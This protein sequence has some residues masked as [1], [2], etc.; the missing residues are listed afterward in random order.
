[1]DRI[2]ECLQWLY[3]SGSL[4]KETGKILNNLGW[5]WLDWM[6]RD[7]I[8][9]WKAHLGCAWMHGLGKSD[10]GK[11]VEVVS[12][13]DLLV[14]ILVLNFLIMD[15]Q[16]IGC[17]CPQYSHLLSCLYW[18]MTKTSWVWFTYTRAGSGGRG[19]AVLGR[20]AR[21]F[22]HKGSGLKLVWR[23][24]RGSMGPTVTDIAPQPPLAWLFGDL[25]LV[26][27]DWPAT[28]PSLSSLAQ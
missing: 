26:L 7:W 18:K 11:Q 5:N 21:L 6:S 14:W 20:E 27:W 24:S 17:F 16:Y 8:A 9:G 28:F 1:M 3:S 25:C 15:C 22:F 12:E 4:W 23:G 13:S 19:L 2:V 10:R